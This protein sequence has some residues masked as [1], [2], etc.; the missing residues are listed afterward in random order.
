MCYKNSTN[1]FKREVIIFSTCTYDEVQDGLDLP[2]STYLYLYLYLSYL[3]LPLPVLYLP[4]S[5]G[6]TR[7]RED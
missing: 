7:R 2:T 6:W 1:T 5:L 4:L 3:Y